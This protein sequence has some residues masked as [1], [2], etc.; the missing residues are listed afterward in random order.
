MQLVEGRSIL[1]TGNCGCSGYELSGGVIYVLIIFLLDPHKE[2]VVY[3]VPCVAG[4]I[5]VLLSV[6]HSKKKQDSNGRIE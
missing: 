2:K 4:T 1:S 3:F 6:W 5:A